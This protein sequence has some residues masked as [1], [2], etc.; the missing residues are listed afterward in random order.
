[1]YNLLRSDDLIDG[2]LAITSQEGKFQAY[3]F[4]FSG[5][6][7]IVRESKEKIASASKT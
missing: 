5:C 6:K 1:M 4:T 3:A 7:D 2:T